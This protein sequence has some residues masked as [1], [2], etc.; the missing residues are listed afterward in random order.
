[1]YEDLLTLGFLASF[2]MLNTASFFFKAQDWAWSPGGFHT[3]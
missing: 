1:M 2:E 3:C